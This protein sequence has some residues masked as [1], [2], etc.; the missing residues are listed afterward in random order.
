MHGYTYIVLGLHGGNL[1]C[2]CEIA[3][4]LDVWL[5]LIIKDNQSVSIGIKTPLKHL[6]ILEIRMCVC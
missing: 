3:W 2:R 4:L 1:Y 5:L 6:R